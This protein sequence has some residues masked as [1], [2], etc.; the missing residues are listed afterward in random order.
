MA[1]RKRLP[2]YKKRRR[3]AKRS[4][5]EYIK[6]A[7]NLSLLVPSLRPLAKRKK[8][9]SVEKARIT[10]KERILKGVPNIF[11]VS[12]Q[13]AK[14]LGNQTFA[15]G[16]QG[17]QLR[18]VPENANI[19]FKGKDI[20][21]EYNG[22]RYLYWHL[23]RATVRSRRGM[24]D[25]G[26]SAFNQQFPIDIVAELAEKAFKTENV[27]QINL[28]AHAGIVGNP[29]H[30]VE[31]FIQWVN[32]KWSAGRYISTVTNAN[33][34]NTYS[35]SSDPGKWVNGI[36]ILLEDAEYAKR[37][38]ALIRKHKHVQEDLEAAGRAHR[39]RERKR[40]AAKGLLDVAGTPLP[41]KKRK[42]PVKRKKGKR[43]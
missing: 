41:K 19:Q 43:K 13:Q 35:T 8:L 10:R 36:A 24:R 28:W 38:K 1:R 30:T 4:D 32:D 20:V 12:R 31:E 18:G 21:V 17:I 15:T 3:K 9:K 39:E 2:Q 33:T 23:S 29:Q 16:V 25:A 27:V 22:R 14:K 5:A 7:I 34:G 42:A 40:L 6:S 26:Q 11:P 37:R